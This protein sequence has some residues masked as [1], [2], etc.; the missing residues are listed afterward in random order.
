VPERGD[1]NR[2][3]KPQDAA[4]RLDGELRS[5]ISQAIVSIHAEHYGKGAT[6]AKTYVWDNLV[7]CVLRD[8]L[9]TAERTLVDAGR[10]DAVRELR[11]TF[12]SSMEQTFRAEVERLTARRVQSLLSQVD[13]AAELAIQVF[14]LEPYD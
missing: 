14:L 8:V 10:A 6:Q 7:V 4:P 11:S 5:A 3:M 2:E 13:P 12:Q 1:P 9:T